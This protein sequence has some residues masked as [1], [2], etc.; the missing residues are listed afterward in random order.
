M[1]NKLEALLKIVYTQVDYL[2]ISEA[3]LD[4]SFPTAQFNLPGFRNPCR[5]DITTRNGGLLVYLNGDIPSRMISIRDCSS[6]IQI[7]PVEMNLKQKWLV[8]A[9]YIPPSQYKSYFI[10][11][12][13][14]VLDKCRS[15][16][17]NIAVLGDLN[18]E[19]QTKK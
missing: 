6:D 5:K 1:R 12:L 15:N 11:K 14:K 4:S 10:T 9:I 16:F 7:L 8:V 17:E 13:T 2:A 19:K 18:M 3:K